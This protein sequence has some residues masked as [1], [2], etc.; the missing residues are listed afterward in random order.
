MTLEISLPYTLRGKGRNWHLFLG[1]DDDDAT[2]RER[3]GD[4]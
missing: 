4:S 2:Y 3:E 1:V